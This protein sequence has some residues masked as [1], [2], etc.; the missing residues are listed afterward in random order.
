MTVAP[1]TINGCERPASCRGWCHSHYQ[2]WRVNKQVWTPRVSVPPLTRYWLHIDDSGGPD[3]CWPWTGSISDQGYGVFRTGMKR[4]GAHR[5]GYAARVGPIPV[6]HGVLHRCDNRPCQNDQHWFTGTN[7]DNVAD[8]VAK[9]RSRSARG[10]DHYRA[11]LTEQ[12][13]REIRAAAPFMQRRALATAYDVSETTICEIA[14][15]RSWAHIV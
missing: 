3:A 11:V 10:A 15:R 1:C 9:G 4:T 5:W 13:V 7:A 8:R 14:A 2:F 6:G 12:D